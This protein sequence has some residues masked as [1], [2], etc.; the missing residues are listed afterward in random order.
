MKTATIRDLRNEFARLSKWLER[1]ETIEILKRGK[2]I[3]D[4]V[5]GGGS[6]MSSG[7]GYGLGV[8]PSKVRGLPRALGTRSA[9][10]LPRLRI[11]IVSPRSS[12]LESRANSFRKS[13]MV[14]VFMV[15]QLYHEK[16]LSNGNICGRENAVPCG[17]SKVAGLLDCFSANKAP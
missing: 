14:A 4:L 1:G 7:S 9:M 16:K 12:H 13:R 5:P 8:Q 2:P 15:I 6:S 11:S 3:A 10:G 17:H